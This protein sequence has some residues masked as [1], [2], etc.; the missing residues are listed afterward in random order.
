[1]SRAVIFLD[2]TTVSVVIGCRECGHW[3]AFAFTKL[4]AWRTAAA[5]EERT[6]PH[7]HQARNALAMALKRASDTP[8]VPS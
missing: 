5:H 4:E 3:R 6:H 2:C 7:R 1:M 8:R